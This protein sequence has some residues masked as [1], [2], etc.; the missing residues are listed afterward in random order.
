MR[1]T[2]IALAVLAPVGAFAVTKPPGCALLD[3]AACRANR[4]CAWSPP[5]VRGKKSPTTGKPYKI[6]R[7]GYCHRRSLRSSPASPGT[8][9]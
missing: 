4:A 3:E 9:K 8:T 1:K 2:I 6:T 7:R 5:M